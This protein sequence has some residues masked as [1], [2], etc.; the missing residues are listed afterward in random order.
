M[1]LRVLLNMVDINSIWVYNRML[2]S[3]ISI[4]WLS[5]YHYWYMSHRFLTTCL[6]QEEF[7]D[8]KRVIRVFKSKK[9]RQHNGQKKND[10][11]TNN[12]IQNI[13]IKLMIDKYEPH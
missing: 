3:Y 4:Y 13:H 9:D 5:T 8:T 11:S 7:E 12:D 1:T 6:I 2:V 10:K